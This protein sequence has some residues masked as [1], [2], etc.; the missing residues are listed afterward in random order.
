MATLNP[1]TPTVLVE[2][3]G[4]VMLTFTVQAFLAPL[5]GLYLEGRKSPVDDWVLLSGE[6]N[7]YTHTAIFN[8]YQT[9]DG[10]NPFNLTGGQQAT[11]WFEAHPYT[12]VRL[13]AT[14]V[15]GTTATATA[16]A[17]AS[18]DQAYQVQFAPTIDITS[19]NV[20]DAIE[21]VESHIPALSN[22]V[23]LVA[24]PGAPG[25][26]PEVSRYDHSHPTEVDNAI[27][28][29][30]TRAPSQGAV[31][32]ALD[33]VDASLL[34]KEQ[35]STA[36]LAGGAITVAGNPAQVNITAV[37]ARFVGNASVLDPA[38][39][40]ITTVAYN[41]VVLPNIATQPSTYIGVDSA[42]ALVLQN[43][44]FTAAQR[45]SVVVLGLAIHS[46]N[47]TVNAI[48]QLMAPDLQ[49]H[50]QL[51][52]LIDAVGPLNLSG[53]EYSANG[54]NLNVNKSAGIVFKLG[55]GYVS[56][57]LAP[58]QVSLAGGTA[59]TFRYRRSNSLEGAD[60]TVVDPAQYESA[61]G[62]LTTLSAASNYSVQRI[63]V[64]QS[65]LTR[66]QYGQAQYSN[67]ADAINGIRTEPFVVEPNMAANGV[68]RGF[69]VVRR[70]ATALNDPTQAAFFAVSKFG[71]SQ[72][73]GA[74]SVITGSD[75][76]TALG[77][78]P[79]NAANKGAANGY[80]PLVSSAVPVAN[81]GTALTAV[82]ANGQIPIGN[83][84]GYNLAQLTAGANVTITN[85]AGT[86]TI[87]STGGGGGGF[88]P[89]ITNSHGGASG[90]ES[91]KILA[92]GN[93]GTNFY[94]FQGSAGGAPTMVAAGSSTNINLDIR[95]KGSGGIDFSTASGG[96]QFLFR[97]LGLA[98]TPATFITAQA[99]ATGVPPVLA[100]GGVATDVQLNVRGK[101]ASGVAVGN[102]SGQG[103]LIGANSG[104]VA[105]SVN[106]NT[107]VTAAGNIGLRNIATGSLPSAST[108]GAGVLV[109]DSTTGELKMS[110]GTSWGAIGAGGGGS[111]AVALLLTATPTAVNTLDF[112]TVFTSAY[113]TYMIELEDIRHS[114]GGGNTLWIRMAIAGALSTS[115]IYNYLRGSYN[116]GN[117]TVDAAFTNAAAQFPVGGTVTASTQ[118]QHARIFIR[119]VNSTTRGKSGELSSVLLPLVNGS[120]M[121][122]ENRLFV[123]SN[124]VLTGFG[125]T[126]ASATNFLTNGQVR[127]YGFKN[128]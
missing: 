73:N 85:G 108:E 6:S 39:T 77:Y 38:T 88:D 66:V 103:L 50:N 37:T 110:N 116:A 87:A 65:G 70:N 126:W 67:M 54:A 61:P 64:F 93:T 10:S 4:G 2:R 7:D 14:G 114:L 26:S 40:V 8:G 104:R 16:S 128:T 94:Q 21:E 41:D 17:S 98:G 102:G 28:I 9:T 52:D 121:G 59:I 125:L 89:T 101:G 68:L 29:S 43:T 34:D 99:N 100:A 33:A 105:H 22:N 60:V 95:S 84:T 44:P 72:S 69:L 82:P 15:L 90:N 47:T 122:Q 36:L 20:Q 19:T 30:T 27:S 56:T 23:P 45:R 48:N 42:G 80:A 31:K 57:P 92:S 51:L 25:T 109:R 18:N 91:V 97:V 58:N 118:G 53:N 106:S 83:G 117:V 32:A 123:N 76:I 74:G 115:T 75:V 13:S 11:F 127:V 96:T 79:E 55:A 78:T 49:S 3:E 71:A 1:N 46:N 124:S 111:G 81:G 12:H 62:V 113:D 35:A 120:E 119:G 112:S 5:T 24:G 86:I 63:Y 107:I